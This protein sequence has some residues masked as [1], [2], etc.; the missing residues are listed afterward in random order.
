MGILRFRVWDGDEMISLS[1]ALS[2]DLVGVQ[3]NRDDGFEIEPFHEGVK[4]LQST[5]LYDENGT[6]VYEG[7]IVK[8]YDGL[9]GITFQ[10][11]VE[12]NDASFCIRSEVST[13]Y[14]WMDYGRLE[15]LGNVFENPELLG[16][17]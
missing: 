13:H 8:G 1:K 16:D 15:V 5:G 3:H 14:R 2:K 6:E 12:F 4:L 7:D 11:I 17:D 9:N 10:G